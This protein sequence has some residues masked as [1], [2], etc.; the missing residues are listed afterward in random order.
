[1][2]GLAVDCCRDCAV[3]EMI[4]KREPTSKVIGYTR[5]TKAGGW[6]L[7]HLDADDIV[8]DDVVVAMFQ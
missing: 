3:G 1:M 2:S 6:P 8:V 5:R 7:L 4:E